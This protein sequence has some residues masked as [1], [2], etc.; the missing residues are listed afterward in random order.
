MRSWTLKFG[1]GLRWC[2]QCVSLVPNSSRKMIWQKSS[3]RTRRHDASCVFSTSLHICQRLSAAVQH[4]SHPSGGRRRRRRR[5]PCFDSAGKYVVSCWRQCQAFL[6]TTG[7]IV[8]LVQDG[9]HLRGGI[10]EDSSSYIS[11][12]WEPPK[13]VFLAVS[14]RF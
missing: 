1:Y 11:V 13:A 8:S 10:S 7:G 12:A 4:Y 3:Y 2:N 5:R 9:S 6:G 14:K